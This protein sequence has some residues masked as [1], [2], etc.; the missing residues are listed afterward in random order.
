MRCVATLI[1]ALVF[2]SASNSFAQ[3][4]VFLDFS[5]FENEL[6]DAAANSGVDIFNSSEIMTIQN[7]IITQLQNQYS[8]FSI[9]FTTANPGG[10]FETI[11]FGAIGPLGV[12]GEATRI[13]FGNDF[14]DDVASIFTASFEDFLEPLDSRAQQIFEVSMALSGTAGHEL[15]HNLG[16][17]H[18][19]AY[20]IASLP[21]SNAT[22]GAFTGGQQNQHIMATGITGLTEGQREVARTFSDLSKVKLNF[23]QGV[24]PDALPVGAEQAA[25]HSTA[26]TAQHI[27]LENLP[28]D[29]SGYNSAAALRGTIDV[30]NEIDF[31]S[32]DLMA[33]DRLTVEVISDF[34]FFDDIDSVLTIF[35]IDGTTA[36]VENDDTFLDGNSINPGNTMYSF[37]SSIFNFEAAASGRYFVAVSTFQGVSTGT[38]ELLFASTLTVT[39]PEPSSFALVG[40]ISSALIFRRRRRFASQ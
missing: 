36:L 20:G 38:Y 12:Y 34:V 14:G 16:L 35:D 8:G 33:G 19:D 40:L 5:G 29:D 39:I 11:D 32:I 25:P 3:I 28:V 17:E 2:F 37:D 1:L 24:T 7:N 21:A 13:D 9:N 31:Y 23:A 4:N 27:D 18:R 6:E 15:G 26:A 22:G 30:A 10:V